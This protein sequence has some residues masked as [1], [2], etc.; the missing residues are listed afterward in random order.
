MASKRELMNTLICTGGSSAKILEAVLHLCAAGLGPATLRILRIDPDA[1][2]GNAERT[3]KLLETYLQCHNRFAKKLGD[4]KL[5]GTELDLFGPGSLKNGF[6]PLQERTLEALLR[7]D[8]LDRTHRNVTQLFFTK[9]EL[10]MTFDQ[11]FR[12]HAAIG[13]GAMSLIS[14]HADRQPWKQVIEKLKGDL[15]GPAGARVVVTGSVFGGTGASAI[16]PVARF[17][18]TIPDM[19]FDRL[20]IGVMALVPYFHF[21]ASTATPWSAPVAMAAKAERF[22]VATRAAAEFY[23]HLRTN[24][25]WPFDAMYWIG[26]SSPV[27]VPYEPGGPR[28]KNDAHFVDLLAALT[29]LEFFAEPQVTQACYYAG[30]AEGMLK[31]PDL[32]LHNPK[33][34]DIKYQLLRFLLAGVVH[35][36]FCN[37]L[38]DNPEIDRRPFCVPWY[39][40]RFA[41]KKDWLGPKGNQDALHLLTD[42]FE[43]YHVPWWQ[44]IHRHDTVQLFNRSAFGSGAVGLEYL[45]NLLW[46]NDGQRQSLEQIDDFFTD[47]VRVP[48]SK[49]GDR[50]GPSYLALLAHA[51]DRYIKREYKGE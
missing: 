32:P 14:L 6:A 27:E 2:N 36:G 13:A 49:S 34:D 1:A 37:A 17:L 48:R 23:D 41:N 9:Q 28:Q 26:D 38:F 5:F 8:N 30:P 46:P 40:D 43:T 39:L 47:M 16:H 35:L 29:C 51:A 42:Y 19:N 3:N 44:Q 24:N 33:R 45:A 10:A 22:P 20:K 4:L 11:G 50:G 15:A 21:A 12:G 31:W 18:R 25:D 7:H